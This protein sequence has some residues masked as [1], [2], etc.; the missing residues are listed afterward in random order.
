MTKLKRR[1]VSITFSF[2]LTLGIAA[3]I[4]GLPF[5]SN[6]IEDLRGY[7]YET[8][9]AR[10]YEWAGPK[11][12][13]TI[14]INRLININ[15]ITLAKL[16]KNDLILMTVVDPGCGACKI[17]QEQFRFLDE[18]LE[19]RAIDRYLVCFSQKVSPS[20]L[21]DYVKTLDLSTDS[22]SWSGDL[23]SVPTSIAKI[24]FPSH[25]LV[26]SNGIVIRTFPGTSAEK[27][28]RNRMVKRVLEEVLTEKNRRLAEAG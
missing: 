21:S 2:I 26:D 10:G 17:T 18:N 6:L 11:Q 19:G 20:G 12:G 8:T 5:F 13:E 9:I 14:D 1:L 15:G 3:V 27:R 4:R 16:S 7:D 28:V 22:L 24:V 23:E 25:I